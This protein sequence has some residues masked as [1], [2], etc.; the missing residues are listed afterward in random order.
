VTVNDGQQAVIERRILDVFRWEACRVDAASL[1]TA[2]EIVESV[3]REFRELVGRSDGLPL[4]VRVEVEGACPAHESLTARIHHWTNEIRAAALD[5]SGGDAWIEKI[6]LRTS[7]PVRRDGAQTD[8]PV[9]ELIQFLEELRGDE[10]QFAMLR[11]EFADLKRKL[12]PELLEGTGALDLDS[13]QALRDLLDE[14]RQILS[15]RLL[16][17]QE[18]V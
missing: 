3:R 18:P 4:A 15:M 8:G 12:P 14:V 5:A 2:D 13:P 10:S 16:A 7:L 1:E 6:K 9:G 17:K 11:N